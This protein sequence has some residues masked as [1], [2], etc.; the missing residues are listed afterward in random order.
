MPVNLSKLSIAQA[1]D[2]LKRGDFT[3]VEL[4]QAHLD[5]IAEKNKEVNAYLEV[6]D[7]ALDSAKEAD[8]RIKSGKAAV[9]TGIPCGIKDNILIQGKRAGGASRILEPYHAAYDATAIARLKAEGAI[10][11]GRTN[12]DEFAMGSSTENSAYGSTKNPHDLSRVAGGSSGGSAAAVAMDAAL[13]ALGSDTGGSVR[14][15]AS[16]C[17]VVGLKPTYGSISRSGL[18][19]MGSSLDVIGPLAKTVADAEIVFSALSGRD[20]KDATS[21]GPAASVRNEKKRKPRIGVPRHFLEGGG[22][23]PGVTATFDAALKSLKN[24]GY[25]IADIRL[26]SIAHALAVYY[27]VMPAE[28]S[29]NMARYDGVKYGLHADGKDVIGDYFETRRAG[30]G[31]EVVRRIL[32]GTYVLSAGYYDAYYNRAIAVR[33]MITDEFLETFQSVDL[34]A[35]P[36]APTP[37]FK[38]G[39]KSKDPMSMYLQDIFTVTANLTGMPAISIPCGTAPAEGQNLPVGL[40]FMASHGNERALF[41]A[42]KDFSGE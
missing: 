11:L 1:H 33:G 25:E 20:E 10:F 21:I 31:Q 5:L 29:A 34:I 16:Y 30:F 37:A 36:T 40:Q 18:M 14:Q 28:V 2:H 35:T 38:L 9:L 39:E 17:G 26:P 42:G 3:A 4:V 19:A 24:K 32:L 27:I 6:F 13:F 23:D 7:D 12:M 8:K 41:E 15:P 22:I